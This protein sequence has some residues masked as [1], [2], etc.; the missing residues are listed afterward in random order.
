MEQPS[1][2]ALAVRQAIVD[3]MMDAFDAGLERHQI[4]ADQQ[5]ALQLAV[6]VMVFVTLAGQTLRV[7]SAAT[8]VESLVPS[9]CMEMEKIALYSTVMKHGGDAA[10]AYAAMIGQ[11][12]RPYGGQP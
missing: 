7:G 4:A 5:E 11:G 12:P 3:A 8:W 10:A 6:A 2:G 9:M 1:L